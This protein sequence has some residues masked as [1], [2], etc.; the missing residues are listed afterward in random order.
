MTNVS[1]KVLLLWCYTST[2]QWFLSKKNG[3]LSPFYKFSTAP[4][5]ADRPICIRVSKNWLPSKLFSLNFAFS[6]THKTSEWKDKHN[7][8]DNEDADTVTFDMVNTFVF[9][10][11]LT[12]GLTG[13]EVVT[14]PHLLIMVSL[15]NCNK[16]TFCSLCYGKKVKQNAKKNDGKTIPC[17]I[18]KL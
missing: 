8:V 10:P 4:R 5:P 7:L 1:I 3:F 15:L 11:D 16:E 12:K 6:L 9:R 2:T 18:P 14:I 13:N 17:K